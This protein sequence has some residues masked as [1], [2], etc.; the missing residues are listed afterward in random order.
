GAGSGACTTWR[1]SAAAMRTQMSLWSASVIRTWKRFA[2]SGATTAVQAS[3]DVVPASQLREAYTKIR[4]LERALGRKTMEIEI[5]RAAQE[6]VKKTPSL[7]RE[8][9]R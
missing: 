5:L 4:E 7:R 6:I 9:G 2:E 1:A 8:S 3:E